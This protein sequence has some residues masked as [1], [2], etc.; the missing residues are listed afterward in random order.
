MCRKVPAPPWHGPTDVSRGC[1][2]CLLLKSPSLSKRKPFRCN[3]GLFTW[4]R[5][6]KGENL[7]QTLKVEMSFSCGE[8]N[9]S[10]NSTNSIC[11]HI[12]HIHIIHKVPRPEA[13][14]FS[15]LSDHCSAEVST[16]TFHAQGSDSEKPPLDETHPHTFKS[17]ISHDVVPLFTG[18]FIYD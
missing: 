15:T 13:S 6:I 3:N 9:H 5:G 17:F 2:R 8:E 10:P 12:S 16:T 4:E 7:N 18:S 11:H 1:I 14:A